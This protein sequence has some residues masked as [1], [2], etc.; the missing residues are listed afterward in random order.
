[1][2]KGKKSN[3][4]FYAV[5]IRIK[6]NAFVVTVTSSPRLTNN[7]VSIFTQGFREGINMLLTTDRNGNVNKTGKLFINIIGG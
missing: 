1:M 3:H 7:L 4:D 2:P 5:S 6:D